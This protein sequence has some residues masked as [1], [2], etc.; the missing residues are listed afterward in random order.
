MH[1]EHIEQTNKCTR[2]VYRFYG[3]VSGSSVDVCLNEYRDEYRE[4]PRHKWKAIQKWNRLMTR[5]NTC[6]RPEISGELISKAVNG[7]RE[8]VQWNFDR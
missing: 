7:I 1:Y 2:Q 3:L 5:D 8:C 4:T 6:E